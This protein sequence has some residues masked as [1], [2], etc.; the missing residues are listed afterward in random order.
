L[1][2]AGTFETMGKINKKKM[3]EKFKEIYNPNNLI[4]CVVGNADFEEVS[5]FAEKNFGNEKGKIP[6]QKLK[7]KNESRIEKRKGVDQANLVFAYHVPLST[8]KKSNAAQILSALMAEGLSSRLLL[9]IREKRNLAYAVHGGSDLN[10]K[11]GYNFIYVGTMKENIEQV[12]KLI[13][14]EFEKVAKGLSEKEL[15]GIKEQLIGQHQIS[16]EDSQTQM[17]NLL[18]YETEGNAK[19]FYDFEKKIRNVKLEDVKKLA[20][21]KNYSFFALVPE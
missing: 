12:K 8:D 3:T 14:N 18:F 19:K 10:K 7:I 16:L 17:A 5:K 6:I 9:E 13:L 15:N 11:F 20:K 2:L 1:N 21:L 4:L